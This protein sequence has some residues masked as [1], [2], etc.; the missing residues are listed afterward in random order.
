MTTTI[1]VE[2]SIDAICQA[3]NS[4]YGINAL[5]YGEATE[6]LLENSGANYVTL[7]GSRYCS[8]D[9]GYEVVYFVARQ[10]A[11]PTTEKGGG[12]ANVLSRSV[13]FKLLGNSKKFG[14]EMV[15][16]NILNATTGVAY[17]GSSFDSKNIA[18][19]YFGLV[20]YDFETSFFSVDFKVTEKITCLPCGK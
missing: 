14:A 10:S 13:S 12:R 15:F 5:F 2:N 20:D 18:T 6:S 9:D 17:E 19:T 3:I 1:N 7:D 16:A 4:I 8:V 11:N